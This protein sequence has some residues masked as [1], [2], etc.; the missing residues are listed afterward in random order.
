MG[1]MW[2]MKVFILVHFCG[3][4]SI[5]FLKNEQPGSVAITLFFANGSYWCEDMYSC[6]GDGLHYLTIKTGTRSPESQ[7]TAV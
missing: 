1:L 3:S 4:I 6:N 5:I 7:H 2:T